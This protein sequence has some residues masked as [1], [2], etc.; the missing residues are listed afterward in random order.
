MT[1]IEPRVVPYSYLRAVYD[2]LRDFGCEELEEMLAER[3]VVKAERL[4]R[5]ITESVKNLVNY[6]NRHE[7]FLSSSYGRK[8]RELTDQKF[9]E[10]I[11]AALRKENSPIFTDGIAPF[12]TVAFE[13]SPL[14]TT[15]SVWEDGSP[16]SDSGAG[17]IDV[18]AASSGDLLPCVCEVK[19]AQDRGAVLALIQALAYSMELITENQ[20]LRLEKFY[21]E[22]FAPV[23]T[24]EGPFLDI[25]IIGESTKKMK[26]LEQA[27][28]IVAAL[29]PPEN[30]ELNKY[31]RKV[32]FLK[33]R[34]LPG[35][36]AEISMA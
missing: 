3:F 24:L 9:A 17:G 16:A 26:G 25:A 34:R 20:R 18:L 33:A 4:D 8:S 19:S 12:H 27:K 22:S 29:S 32:L 7:G 2:F 10:W 11:V 14:R 1:N 21:P 30:S 36:R 13:V 23:S 28:K 31:V 5:L 35:N 15:N 6:D